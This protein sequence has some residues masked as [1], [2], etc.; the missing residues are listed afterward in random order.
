MATKTVI[1]P[2]PKW[3]SLKKKLFARSRISGQ[4]I[5][6][7]YYRQTHYFHNRQEPAVFADLLHNQINKH[8]PNSK[9]I[10]CF[11][12]LKPPLIFLTNCLNPAGGRN[13]PVF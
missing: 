4:F 12:P 6:N 3:L 13:Q 7:N 9:V 1:L 8:A 2:P 5:Y 11:H 10:V